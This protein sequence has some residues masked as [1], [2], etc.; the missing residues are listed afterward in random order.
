M[1]GVGVAHGDRIADLLGGNDQIRAVDPAFRP[2]PASVLG[3]DRQPRHRR[4]RG[5]HRRL[6]AFL[7]RQHQAVPGAVELHA[8]RTAFDRMALVERA[9]R[10]NVRFAVGLVQRPGCQTQADVVFVLRMFL[11]LTDVDGHRH[12]GIW[13]RRERFELGVADGGAAITALRLVGGRFA[14]G[15]E[16]DDVE[17]E[18]PLLP[19]AAPAIDQALEHRQVVLSLFLVGLALIPEYAAHRMADQGFD[20]GHVVLILGIGWRVARGDIPPA[21]DPGARHRGIQQ[22]HGNQQLALQ[23]VAEHIRDAVAAT[24]GV[25]STG[26][27]GII[28]KAQGRALGIEIRAARVVFHRHVRLPRAQPEFTDQDVGKRLRL[29]LAAGAGDHR[30]CVAGGRI[31][32][33]L[34]LVG[35]HGLELHLEAAITTGF[36]GTLL[37]IQRNADFRPRQ[38]PAPDRDQHLLLEHRVVV[39][40]AS[41]PRCQ[42][43][44]DRGFREIRR[45]LG[46]RQRAGGC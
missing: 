42:L 21:F 34:E 2:V 37:P 40:G 5:R 41:H 17:R 15:R 45:Q 1:L 16:L 7:L 25:G 9:A 29:L 28:E 39:E 38:R 27:P 19:G 10:H 18:I 36:G 6:V 4:I 23:L 44:R 43:Q 26:R 30:Q 8:D 11:L 35:R 3:L 31:V 46:G 14:D 20:S 22:A 32:H 33:R 13:D 24:T 12:A